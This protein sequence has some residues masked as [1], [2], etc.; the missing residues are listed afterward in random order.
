M[1]TLTFP[2]WHFL[3]A[4]LAGWIHREQQ[5]RLE[6]VQTEL[7]VAREML[8]K[9]TGEIVCRER[10]GGLLKYDRRRVA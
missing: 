4:C 2:A 5:Q 3:L 1:S 8:G 10:L 6:Y 9:A 7:A